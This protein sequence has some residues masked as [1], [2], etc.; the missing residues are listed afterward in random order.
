M[1][2]REIILALFHPAT[3]HAKGCLTRDP[4]FN[5]PCQCGWSQIAGRYNAA[6]RLARE[7]AAKHHKSEIEPMAGENW[8]DDAALA[9]G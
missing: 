1:N 4:H 8:D 2:D 7:I 3:G 9:H 6:L 5:G